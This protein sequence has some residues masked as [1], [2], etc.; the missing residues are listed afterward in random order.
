MRKPIVF[1]VVLSLFS[2]PLL[3]DGAATF[4]AK[5]AMCH[6]ADGKGQTPMGKSLKLR[7]LTSAEVQKQTDEQL[8]ATTTNGKNKM[9]S[10]KGKLTDAEIKAVVGAVRDL[11]KK[12]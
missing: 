7:D 10:F 2:L 5:C 3:A 11:A 8:I 4:K 9:P 6:G 12:K 1:L